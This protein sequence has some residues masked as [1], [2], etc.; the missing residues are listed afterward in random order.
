MNDSATGLMG[1]MAVV[2]TGVF[3]IV[4]LAI[5][6]VMIASLW[7]VFAKAGQPGWAAIVPI[8][9][10]VV[11][12]QITGR[13]LWWIILFMIPLANII[14]GILVAVDLAKSFGQSTGFA[15]GLVFLGFI[16]FPILGFG[17]A[18]YLGPAA[19]GAGTAALGAAS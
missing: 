5:G 9:N 6:V 2:F 12:L 17:S 15:L 3:L 19:A 13:P 4:M 7:K 16:F 10:A 8:Y 18:R 1:G 11:L 14:V